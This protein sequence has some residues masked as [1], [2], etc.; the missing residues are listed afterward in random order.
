MWIKQLLLGI[1]GCCGGLS[2]AAGVFTVFTAVGLVPR[3]ADRT[4]SADHIMLYENMIILG[5]LWGTVYSLF[6]KL[7]LSPGYG[8]S[9]YLYSLQNIKT[10]QIAVLI[11]YGIFTG[12]YVGTL[13]VSV[14]EML[15]AI[16]AMAHRVKLKRGIGIVIA[17]FAVG[18][19]AGSLFYY[20]VGVYAW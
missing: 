6:G 3:F 9:K 10:L 5:T 13:A 4:K 18:K 7:L 15:D 17:S 1:G 11:L 8:I 16:P 20:F 2:V 12:I 19:L 14:A